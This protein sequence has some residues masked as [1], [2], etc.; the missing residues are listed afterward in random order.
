MLDLRRLAA[1][2]AVAA[3]GS[4]SAAA[5]ALNF[6]QSVVSHHVAQLE[7]ELGVTL[8]ERGRRPIRLTPAGERLHAHAGAILGA[9][10][11]AE[12]DLRAVAGL[13]SGTL[14]VGA[15]LTACTTFI[16][17]A[18]GLFA[19]GHPSIDVRLE[20]LEPPV[21]LPRLITGELDLAVAWDFAEPDPRLERA[22]LLDDH[23][24]IVVPP[25]HRL[26]KRRSVRVKDLEG[27]RLNGP[28]AVGAGIQYRTMLEE[29]CAREGFSPDIRHVVTD[30]T[31]ARAFVAAG[32]SVAMMPELSIPH[33]RPDVVVKPLRDVAPFRTVHAMWMRGR[34]VPS[35]APMV[36]ALREAA[37]RMF[38]TS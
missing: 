33:P 7:K 10:R 37:V 22:A 12:Q 21:A 23:Y 32:L 5:L 18:L 26:A 6:T 8:V 19:E 34:R 1:F 36:A 14:R 2:H 16:P 11:A 13:E 15:F 20:Q 35:L 38:G 28:R 29:L 4:F 9:T 17:A 3:H 24:R 27:E 30:V 25:G 31:V